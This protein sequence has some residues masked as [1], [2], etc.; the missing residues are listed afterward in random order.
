MDLKVGNMMTATPREPVEN[1]VCPHC[2]HVGPMP[3]LKLPSPQQ[4]SGIDNKTGLMANRIVINVG[5]PGGPEEL[6]DLPNGMATTQD[7]IR[8]L[9][10]AASER[11]ARAGKPRPNKE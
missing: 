9:V 3:L 2:G 6:V 4:F 11:R 1:R 10:D 5:L 8:A 7:E